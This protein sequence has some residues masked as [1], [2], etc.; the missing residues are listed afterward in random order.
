MHRLA[1]VIVILLVK[2]YSAFDSMASLEA[3]TFLVPCWTGLAVGP[4]VGLSKAKA[5]T[6]WLTLNWLIRLRWVLTLHV[7]RF[8]WGPIQPHGYPRWTPLHAR[9]L[10]L[11]F[12]MGSTSAWRTSFW[13]LL[14]SDLRLHEVYIFFEGQSFLR[15]KY[16]LPELQSH[17]Y[18]NSRRWSKPTEEALFNPINLKWFHWKTPHFNEEINS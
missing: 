9:G 7:N 12:N 16:L 13:Q 2:P 14:I 11:V 4:V 5:T 1:L 6:W 18:A 15:E 8:P 3:A 17:S 10:F